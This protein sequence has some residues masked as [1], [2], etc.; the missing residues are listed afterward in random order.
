MRLRRGRALQV[1]RDRRCRRAGRQLGDRGERAEAPL[2]VFYPSACHA[3]RSAVLRRP[4]ILHYSILQPDPVLMVMSF[5]TESNLSAAP[6]QPIGAFLPVK[7]IDRPEHM[8]RLA[9]QV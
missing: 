9:A 4:A 5:A 7:G 1:Q 2:R 8:R 3:L 6:V